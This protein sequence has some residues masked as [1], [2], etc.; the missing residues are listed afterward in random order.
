MKKIIYVTLIL[1][2]NFFFSNAQKEMKK[3]LKEIEKSDSTVWFG[4]DFSNAKLIGDF[5]DRKNIMESSLDAWN[6]MLVSSDML[7]SYKT[8]PFLYDFTE[9]SKRNK[10]IQEKDL[11]A[12]LPMSLTKD[13][14]QSI[15][16][17]Y[18]PVIT[19]GKGL[20]FIVESFDKNREEARIW[21]VYFQIETKKVLY[22]EPIMGRASGVN[23]VNHWG[24]AIHRI[25]YASTFHPSLYV[26]NGIFFIMVAASL[27][28]FIFN[29]G[30]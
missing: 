7:K 1:C 28:L 18:D 9:I 16:N 26:A 14:I 4:I 15:I 22:A 13:K 12:I 27:C 19:K 25:I 23:I 11:F 3:V 8:K 29:T 6:S 10:Q 21:F 24:T 30:F 17:E 5:P 2:C 20:V